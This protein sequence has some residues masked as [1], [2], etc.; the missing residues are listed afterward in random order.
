MK[1]DKGATELFG[2]GFIED[3]FPAFLTNIWSTQ[4]YKKAMGMFEELYAIFAR[5]FKEHEE[6]FDPGLCIIK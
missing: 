1:L 3:L 2:K 6:T 4:R 5:K